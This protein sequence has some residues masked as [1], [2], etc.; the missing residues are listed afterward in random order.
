MRYMGCFF[1][2]IRISLILTAI[3]SPLVS[4]AAAEGAQIGQALSPGQRLHH[5]LCFGVLLEQPVHL[6][7]AGSRPGR[8]PAFSAAT[9]DFGVPA[10]LGRHRLDDCLDPFEVLVVDIDLTQER[11]GPRKHSNDVLRDPI[12]RMVWNCFRKSSRVNSPFCILRAASSASFWSK[13]SSAFSIRLRT[14]P[15]PRMREAMRSG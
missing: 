3:N 12:R 1:L 4:S 14:S 11:T 8:D 7:R 10:L 2:P 5:L 13:V 9:D 6:L 15:I